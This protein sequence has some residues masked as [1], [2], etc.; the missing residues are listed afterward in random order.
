MKEFKL[1]GYCYGTNHQKCYFMREMTGGSKFC[2]LWMRNIVGI[3][4]NKR[5]LF[6]CTFCNA[7]SVVINSNAGAAFVENPPETDVGGRSISNF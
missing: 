4:N 3:M 1:D 6:K 2:G 7:S 5:K